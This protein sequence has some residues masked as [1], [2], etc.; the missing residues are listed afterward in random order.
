VKDTKVTLSLD[1]TDPQELEL[2]PL[3]FAYNHVGTEVARALRVGDMENVMSLQPPLNELRHELERRGVLGHFINLKGIENQE[4][5]ERTD[6]ASQAERT[7]GEQ[8]ER[9]LN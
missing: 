1:L 4:L 8:G 9:N 2:F 7:Q 6:Q 5:L 3:I